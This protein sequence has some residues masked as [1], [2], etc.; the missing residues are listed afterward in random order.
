MFKVTCHYRYLFVGHS[1][2]LTNFGVFSMLHL[3]EVC[4][5]IVQRCKLLRFF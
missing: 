5:T 3:A 1:T 2:V 4:S